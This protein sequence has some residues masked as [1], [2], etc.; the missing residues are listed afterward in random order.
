MKRLIS[1]ALF[2]ISNIC[3]VAQTTRTYTIPFSKEDFNIIKTENGDLITSNAYD[4]RYDYKS[5]KPAIPYIIINL[6][7]PEYQQLKN[8]QI[9]IIDSTQTTS[10]VILCN[11][12]QLTLTSSSDRVKNRSSSNYPLLDYPFDTIF[13]GETDL[14]EYK[15]ASFRISPIAYNAI[16]RTI[17]WANAINITINSEPHLN[18]KNS[19]PQSTL[20]TNILEKIIYNKEDIYTPSQKTIAYSITSTEKPQTQY[21]II[22]SDSL[23]DC[24]LPLVNW[25]TAKGVKSEIVTTEN[26]YEQYSGTTPQLKIKECIKRYYQN[27]LKFVLL[28][29]D[30]IIIPTQGC[31]DSIYTPNMGNIIDNNIPTDLFYASLSSNGR[32][33]WNADGDSLIGEDCDS[34]YYY[35]DI[36]IGRAP[37]RTK[38]QANI[39][40]TK[41]INY[42]LHPSTTGHHNKMLL[43]GVELG[44]TLNGHSDSEYRSESMFNTYIKPYWTNVD[45]KRFYDT[46]TDFGGGSP[47]DT[48]INPINLMNQI[49]K[50]YH[51]IHMKTHG[52][53]NS[54][55]M[56]VGTFTGENAYN[57]SNS[58]PTIITT[59]SCNGNAFDAPERCLSEAFLHSP[60]NNT[61]AY[62]GPSRAGLSSSS[63]SLLGPSIRYV[64]Y[65]YEGILKDKLT[66]GEALAKSK[67]IEAA[68]CQTLCEQRWVH[69]GLNLM[70][71]PNLTIYTD[72]LQR[73]KGVEW[74]FMAN[75]LVIKTDS[76]GCTAIL[77]SK[78][79]NGNSFF[80]IQTC[81]TSSAPVSYDFYITSPLED[82]QLCLTAPNHIPILI[83]DLDNTYIQNSTYRGT[84]NITGN[85]IF[86]GSNVTPIKEEGPVVIE[87]G[88]VVFDATNSVTIKNNFECQLGATLTI[89]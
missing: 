63:Y 73:I 33:D 34:V 20:T 85:N 80:E 72:S 61:V 86:I 43:S 83:Q 53:K 75:H 41:N 81:N 55:N 78:N 76:H 24:F 77:S 15:Y 58:T 39:F 35:S 32:F 12:P 1:I 25:K 49:S 57:I 62:L 38:E 23:K 74:T 66:I 7:L 13:L 64:A 47:F 88:S 44:K 50:G 65:F 89:K 19:V 6:L 70:G 67:G 29:G 11:N 27:G 31:Y 87:S 18:T 3:L 16:S 10:G 79:D 37:I 30:E 22:T 54:W 69:Y 28:G 8:Y 36:A 14:G 26:I 82:Y 59:E 2:L 52:G 5:K 42:E 46:A 21:L 48:I 9:S 56:K 71:D 40:V 4:L 68:F 17:T 84:N 51:H 60:T 45:K